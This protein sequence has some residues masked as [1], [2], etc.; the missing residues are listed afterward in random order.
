LRGSYGYVQGIRIRTA[1]HLFVSQ[2][3]M[4]YC[5]AGSLSDINEAIH[6]VLNEEELKSTVAYTVLGLHHLHTNRSIHRVIILLL[7]L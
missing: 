1:P 6:R 4:E 7:T 5:A 2:I 3:V